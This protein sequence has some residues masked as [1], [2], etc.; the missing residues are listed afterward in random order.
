MFAPRQYLDQKEATGMERPEIYSPT[1][2]E[3]PLTPAGRKLPRLKGVGI[4]PGSE[5]CVC[6]CG[7][8]AMVPSLHQSNVYIK[9]KL[10]VCRVQ[11]CILLDGAKT[12]L[13]CV[14]RRTTPSQGSQ[15]R[16]ENGNLRKMGWT[17]LHGTMF[18]PRECLYQ[19]EAMGME[20][21]EMHSPTRYKNP[22]YLCRPSNY[23]V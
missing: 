2:C 19:K 4:G 13:T 7:L 9:R 5:T 6:W 12:P 3:N 22:S 11:K 15:Y 16:P 10:R 17:C 18:A 8:I 20:R 21:L 1:R 23:S 14:G